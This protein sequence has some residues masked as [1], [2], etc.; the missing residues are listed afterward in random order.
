MERSLGTC[1]YPEHWP[2]QMWADD[3]YR[4]RDAGLT[5]VRPTIDA[6]TLV[7]LGIP[8]FIVTMATQNAPGLA[9]LR[10][11]QFD[12]PPAPLLKGVGLASLVS[13]P[14][15]GVLGLRGIRNLELG[16]G[17]VA[18]LGIVLLAVILDRVSKAA[19]ARV[20]TA[21]KEH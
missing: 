6:A 9:V 7:S 13:A 20:D 4:M 11:H 14:G 10:A 5:W 3:A 12:P 16:V 17:M 19:L 21:R 8:L 18:G 15:L 1:Y 2:R